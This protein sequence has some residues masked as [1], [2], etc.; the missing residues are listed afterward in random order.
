MNFFK[1]ISISSMVF[2]LLSSN[3][4][5]TNLCKTA[6]IRAFS[7]NVE[8]VKKVSDLKKKSNDNDNIYSVDLEG[9]PVAIQ[10]HKIYSEGLNYE[11]YLVV[12]SILISDG[13]DYSE[14]INISALITTSVADDQ[15]SECQIKLIE[16]NEL[17]NQTFKVNFS[18]IHKL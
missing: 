15:K 18:K 3:A 11:K 14:S 6:A 12:Q 4:E 17:N 8:I 13:S 5:A 16:K 7:N 10:T 2:S 1:I 9:S